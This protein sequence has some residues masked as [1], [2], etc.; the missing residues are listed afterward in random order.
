MG[1]KISFRGSERPWEWGMRSS[2]HSGESR[3]GSSTKSKNPERTG[4]SQPMLGEAN[5]KSGEM[6]NRG[7]IGVYAEQNQLTHAGKKR[8]RRRTR[9][10]KQRL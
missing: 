1:G 4:D 7:K 9:G 8:E 10:S 2:L 6:A 3:G 5:S